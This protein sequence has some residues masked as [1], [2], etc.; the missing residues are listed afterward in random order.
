MAV[1][2][3]VRRGKRVLVIDFRYRQADGTLTRYRRDTK[4]PTKAAAREEEKRLLERIARTGSPYESAAEP[5][6][7][8]APSSARAC[9][10]P[11]SSEASAPPSSIG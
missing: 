4:A 5:E 2:E 7:P 3:K 6:P 8:P 1:I 10:S 9:A 11:E